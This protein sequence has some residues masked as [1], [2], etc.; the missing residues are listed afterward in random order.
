MACKSKK[1][2]RSAVFCGV[3]ICREASIGYRLGAV[4][5]PRFCS[6]FFLKVKM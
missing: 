6:I 1:A 5:L 2:G 4:P 3:L